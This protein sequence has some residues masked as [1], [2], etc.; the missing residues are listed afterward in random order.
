MGLLLG[1]LDIAM[2]ICV[3]LVMMCVLLVTM[4]ERL[5]TCVLLVTMCVLLTDGSFSRS[6]SSS[7]SS[8]DNINKEA[9]HCLVFAD[10]YAKKIGTPAS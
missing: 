2:K 4:C 7:V 6:R 8:L 1:R 3:L 5:V 9:I 10:S